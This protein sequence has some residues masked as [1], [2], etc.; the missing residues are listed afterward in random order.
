MKTQITILDLIK[1]CRTTEVIW[2]QELGFTENKEAL[3]TLLDSYVQVAMITMNDE[4]VEYKQFYDMVLE[5]FE[6]NYD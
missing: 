3:K 4:E 5:K 2:R 6:E 1:Q